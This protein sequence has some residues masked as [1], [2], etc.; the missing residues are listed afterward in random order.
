MS[1]IKIRTV[2]EKVILSGILA[3]DLSNTVYS[4]DVSS[5]GPIMMTNNVSLIPLTVPFHL[6]PFCVLSST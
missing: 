3:S 2:I 4:E 1:S 6:Y 5:M